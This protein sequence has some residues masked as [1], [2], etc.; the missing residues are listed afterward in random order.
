M[1]QC[2]LVLNSQIL[3]RRAG[4]AA[5][6][7]SSRV[8]NAGASDEM[9]IVLCGDAGTA[10]VRLTTGDPV[11]LTA[12]VSGLQAGLGDKLGIQIILDCFESALGPVAGILHATER[13][14]RQRQA[15]VI[16]RDHAA[17]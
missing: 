17:L 5:G 10:A 1:E 13:H 7:A 3:V 2:R 12:A 14:L 11:I 4:P 6:W 9:S 8:T 16:D 15:V